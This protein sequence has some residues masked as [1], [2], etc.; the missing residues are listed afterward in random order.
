MDKTAVELFGTADT[1]M[2]DAT[3][4]DC[5]K[6]NA[7]L[8][9]GSIFSTTNVGRI[10]SLIAN[11]YEKC[12]Q[13]D[14]HKNLTNVSTASTIATQQSDRAN[15]ND[16]VMTINEIGMN[17]LNN[18]ENCHFNLE[19][20]NI[21]EDRQQFNAFDTNFVCDNSND[22]IDFGPQ[23]NPQLSN[24]TKSMLLNEIFDMNPSSASSML[25]RDEMNLIHQSSNLEQN[26]SSFSKNSVTG[27]DDTEEDCD[28]PIMDFLDHS[29]LPTSDEILFNLESFDMFG[30][31]FDHL[32]DDDDGGGG[33]MK[34]NP[35]TIETNSS[36]NSDKI[37]EIDD[38]NQC[39]AM[40]LDSMITED[41]IPVS[42][43]EY[44]RENIDNDLDQFGTSKNIIDNNSIASRTRARRKIAASHHSNE[45]YEIKNESSSS[46]STNNFGFDINLEE[47]NRNDEES[48][49]ADNRRQ[50]DNRNFDMELVD[51]QINVR[52]S[53]S[54]SPSKIYAKNESI[55]LDDGFD[56]IA[57]IPSSS[58][59]KYLPGT[60][61]INRIDPNQSS[62]ENSDPISNDCIN[63]ENDSQN[64]EDKA[65]AA[66]Q[67]ISDYSPEWCYVEDDEARTQSLWL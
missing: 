47:I 39:D 17:S 7:C 38:Q 50:F 58:S 53:F 43:Q 28:E 22:F 29:E 48:F 24:R 65:I 11:D 25:H 33:E 32:V 40:I 10:D 35:K 36:M 64:L 52:P 14:C 63:D 54:R 41:N 30:D 46:S 27:V 67:I 4:T 57:K 2:V 56:R 3:G 1:I 49:T 31:E 34:N 51:S 5:P 44:W 55:V 37:I 13:K 26:Q 8:M 62:I 15:K 19:L 16:V 61:R 6:T 59:C 23:S 20:K 66:L 42:V 45:V 60:E 12:D 18:Y 21:K 9:N